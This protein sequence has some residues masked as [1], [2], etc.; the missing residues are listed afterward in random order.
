MKTLKNSS[1]PNICDAGAEVLKDI[2]PINPTQKLIIGEAITVNT[3]DDD[4]GAPIKAIA[5][6]KNKIIVVTVVGNDRAIWGGLATLNAKIKGVKGVII[7]GS[8]R[9][10]EELQKL[11]FPIF[12]KS[13]KPNAGA[14]LNHGK[15]NIPI[16]IENVQINPNDIIV[17]DCNGVAVIKREE[18]NNIIENVKNIKKKEESIKNKI[19][20]GMDLKDIL[21]L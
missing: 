11:N 9:D 12:S 19:M 21:G 10:I 15:I 20:R 17:G 2:K 3:T 6:S 8:V 4:W 1:V 14:P 5:Q 18:L 13:F 16:T 7:N